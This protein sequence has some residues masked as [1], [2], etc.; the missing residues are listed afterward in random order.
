MLPR[1]FTHI[2]LVGLFGVTLLYR[3]VRE[4]AVPG[5]GNPEHKWSVNVNRAQ[6]SHRKRP[7]DYRST[8]ANALPLTLFP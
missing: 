5:M 3:N 4:L 2:C 1:S 8:T 7:T 6:R